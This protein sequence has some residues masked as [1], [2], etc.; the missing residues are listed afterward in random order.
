MPRYCVE[1]SPTSRSGWV[2]SS[3][4]NATSSGVVQSR[5]FGSPR[6]PSARTA[7]TV[8]PSG[9]AK[10]TRMR[11]DAYTSPGCRSPFA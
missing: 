7:I 11:P 10:G 1:P 6:P 9:S 5:T 3:T 8:S 4:L 2:R